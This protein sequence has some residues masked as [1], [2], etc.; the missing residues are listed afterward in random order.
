MISRHFFPGEKI[1]VDY[2]PTKFKLGDKVVTRSRSE[3][4]IVSICIRSIHETSYTVQFCGGF[5]TMYFENEL[6]KV[7]DLKNMEPK[8]KVGDKVKVTKGCCEGI[9]GKIDYILKAP[10]AGEMTIKGIAY[11]IAYRFS[12]DDLELIKEEPQLTFY[13]QLQSSCGLEVG[14]KVKIWRLPTEYELKNWPGHWSLYNDRTVGEKGVIN[15]IEEDCI[16]V[17][18]NG[19]DVHHFRYPF[20]ILELIEKAK[21]EPEQRLTFSDIPKIV[22]VKVRDKWTRILDEGFSESRAWNRSSCAMCQYVDSCAICPLQKDSWCG[23]SPAR[24]YLLTSKSLETWTKS[25]ETWKKD[26]AEFLCILNKEI[27]KK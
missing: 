15:G 11:G 22:L 27:A 12:M 23:K 13:Q 10:F 20:F 24:L 6:I 17:Y 19:D 3:G 7:E 1:Y 8:F 18:V 2:E 25:L 14:D 16:R 26:V 21:S 5:K 9:T 4:I